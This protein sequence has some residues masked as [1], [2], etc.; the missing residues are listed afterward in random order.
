MR[1]VSAQVDVPGASPGQAD[2]LWCDLARWATF[3]DGFR[4][5]VEVEGG[6][7]AAGGR[8]VWDSTPAGR[9]RVVEQVR[10]H[11]E[12]Q[13]LVTD[14]EDP[15]MR[16]AQTVSFEP[17]QDGVGVTLALEYEL[18]QGGPLTAVTDLLF[19]RRAIRESLRR[20]VDRFAA[21]LAHE[22]RLAGR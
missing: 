21:E 20:T 15:R 10:E 9:G 16:G 7:P 19:I 5:T 12:G 1:T 22:A 11:A 2:E 6:W 8:T 14:V 17:L 4:H 3:V 18:E 13:R